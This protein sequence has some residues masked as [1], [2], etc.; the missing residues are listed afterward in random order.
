MMNLDVI[1]ENSSA[2][3]SVLKSAYRCTFYELQRFTQLGSTELCLAIAQLL[4]DCKIE[5]QKSG[6]G[7]YYQLANGI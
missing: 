2:V 5:Q 1:R 6:G 7:I 4:R 3:Y